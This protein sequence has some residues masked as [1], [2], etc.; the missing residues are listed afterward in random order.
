[1]CPYPVPAL[2]IVFGLELVS[3]KV[4]VDVIVLCVLVQVFE[5]FNTCRVTLTEQPL[6]LIKI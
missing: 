6:E 1:M 3:V 4:G 5:F 2:H